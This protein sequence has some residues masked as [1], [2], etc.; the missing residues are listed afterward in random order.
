MVKSCESCATSMNEIDISLRRTSPREC[1]RLSAPTLSQL[2][3]KIGRTRNPLHAA[4]PRLVV[5]RVGEKRAFAANFKRTW[6]GRGH[7]RTAQRHRLEERQTKSFKA[8]W[9]RQAQG[10]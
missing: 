5:V 8:R 9:K 1:P 7:H 2:G 6:N 10:A 3:V 4:Q